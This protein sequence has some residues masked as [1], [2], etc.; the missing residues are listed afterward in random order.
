MM[1]SK[2][3]VITGATGGIGEA[4]ARLFATRGY[5]LVLTYNN[6]K[7]KA[8]ELYAG[9]STKVRVELV[10]LDLSD[11]EETEMVA[12]NITKLFPTIDVL[13]NNAGIAE[14]ALFTELTNS[15]ISLMVNT[16]LTGTMVF[17]R[18]VAAKMLRTECG[19][20]INVSSIWGEEG[21]SMEVHY[22]AAKAG[23]IG[24]TKALSKELAPM[25]IRANAVTPGAIETNMLKGE[26]LEE[27]SSS[28]PLNRIGSPND[29]AE[30]IAYLA[31]ASYV[32]GAVLKVNGGG[33]L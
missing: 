7:A 5:N 26:D 15:Q 8:L 1:S 17:T 9:L 25:G 19:T 10:K 22:S 24:F 11:L 20:I 29:V 32:T 4:I 12:K 16:N 31:D 18:E 13:V 23:L 6:S 30:A 21:A 28:I 2:T 14:K 3:A 33:I 27:L